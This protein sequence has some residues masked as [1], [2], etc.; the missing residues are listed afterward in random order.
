MLRCVVRCLC[1]VGV[2]V[3]C[4]SN[5]PGICGLGKVV[6]GVCGVVLGI[7]RFL[8]C[9]RVLSF[10]VCFGKALLRCWSSHLCASRNASR[11]SLRHPDP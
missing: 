7:V 3:R 2:G 10:R 6:C 8:C 1:G 5:R 4:G 9:I 11:S